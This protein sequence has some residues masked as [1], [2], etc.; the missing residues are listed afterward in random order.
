MKISLMHLK[1]SVIVGLIHIF[2]LFL[3]RSRRSLYLKVFNSNISLKLNFSLCFWLLLYFLHILL[4]FFVYFH[5][6]IENG[7]FLFNSFLIKHKIIGIIA[8][9]TVFILAFGEISFETV[10]IFGERLVFL[11]FKR[12]CIYGIFFIIWDFVDSVDSLEPE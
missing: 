7:I 11:L 8:A 1:I 3:D 4:I 9:S 10:K 5:H 6:P 2:F 12:G